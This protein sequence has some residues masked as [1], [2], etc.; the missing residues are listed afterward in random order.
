MGENHPLNNGVGLMRAWRAWLCSI[1]GL[2]LAFTHESAFRQELL[3]FLLFLPL[4]LWLGQS[5]LHTLFLISL[6]TLVLIVELL[7]SAIEATIDR[8]GTEHHELSG[9]AKDTA[10]A[11]VLLCLVITALVFIVA[12]Y[13][14]FCT[15]I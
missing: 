4:A 8:I 14:K 11:A 7:N 2:K 15:T 5:T 9:R 6:M 12:I 3:L 13:E 1:N 10:S